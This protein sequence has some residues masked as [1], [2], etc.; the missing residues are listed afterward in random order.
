MLEV[1]SWGAELELVVVLGNRV[2]TAEG[3]SAELLEVGGSHVGQ[4]QVEDEAGLQHLA[5]EVLVRTPVMGVRTGP[6]RLA[7]KYGKGH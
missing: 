4:H 2:L 5:A 6:A 3:R 7:K 1:G